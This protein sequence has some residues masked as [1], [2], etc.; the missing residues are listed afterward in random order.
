MSSIYGF[1]IG[2]GVSIIVILIF[3][4]QITD[5]AKREYDNETI[6]RTPFHRSFFRNSLNTFKD[7]K[8]LVIIG[9]NIVFISLE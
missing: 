2:F 4:N 8:S 1:L 3:T 7:I 6:Y 9:H 5:L